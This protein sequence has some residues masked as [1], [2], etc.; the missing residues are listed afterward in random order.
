MVF[1]HFA[2]TIKCSNS[3]AC[4]VLAFLWLE[5]SW[6]SS[7]RETERS[8]THSPLTLPPLGW[9]GLKFIRRAH[10]LGY[11]EKVV[12]R[13]R[14]F[15]GAKIH[16]INTGSFRKLYTHAEAH[17]VSSMLWTLH[18]TERLQVPVG[19][20]ISEGHRVKRPGGIYRQR[21]LT[22]RDCSFLSVGA[23]GNSEIFCPCPNSP[24][25]SK[26]VS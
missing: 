11:R 4:S 6:S 22:L 19:G 12:R 13:E 24:A 17:P 21:V 14:T 23:H 9:L 3:P 25:P 8:N 16:L 7:Q 2:K 10:F 20:G 5:R 1:F 26:Y 15:K 18:K